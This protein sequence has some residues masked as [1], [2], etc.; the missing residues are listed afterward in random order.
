MSRSQLTFWST[1]LTKAEHMCE[2]KNKRLWREVLDHLLTGPPSHHFFPPL[3]NQ[4]R[5]QHFRIDA[6]VQHV[7]LTSF[8]PT[9]TLISTVLVSVVWCTDDYVL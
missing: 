3:T 2:M 5:G 7:I 9:M 1:E 8:C 6:E 4:L